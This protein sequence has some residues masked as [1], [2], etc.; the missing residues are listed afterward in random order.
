MQGLYA[1]T[2]LLLCATRPLLR[3]A[4]PRVT[5]QLVANHTL[6]DDITVWWLHQAKEDCVYL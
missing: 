1:I 2:C 5:D 4:I 3:A 6:F